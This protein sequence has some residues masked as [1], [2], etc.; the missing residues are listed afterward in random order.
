MDRKKKILFNKQINIGINLLIKRKI[1]YCIENIIQIVD[2]SNYALIEQR[3][4]TSIFRSSRKCSELEICRP[5]T[6]VWGPLLT[7]LWVGKFTS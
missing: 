1:S 4:I 7:S 6:L 5:K 3:G 2:A